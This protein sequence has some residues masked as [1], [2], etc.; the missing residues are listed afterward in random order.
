[1]AVST[2]NI[3]VVCLAALSALW[4]CAAYDAIREAFRVKTLPPPPDDG[5]LRAM[6]RRL[7]EH[8]DRLAGIALSG[9]PRR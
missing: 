9:K 5:R 6:E 7:E 1:M 4:I 8:E 2:L 3:I